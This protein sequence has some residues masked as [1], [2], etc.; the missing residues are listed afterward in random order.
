M[1]FGES[2]KNTLKKIAS[3]ISFTDKEFNEILKELQRELIKADVSVQQVLE[4][5]NK[6]KDRVK[7]EKLP[8]GLTKKEHVI[9]I[10]YDELTNLLG[11][12]SREVIIV[13]KPFKI[14]LV[15]LFGS[16]KTTTAGKLA[17]YYV[18]RGYSTLLVQT[19]TY[20]PAAL[21][22]LT[23]LGKKINVHVIGPK[24]NAPLSKE[25]LV[26]WL[27]EVEHTFTNY[28]IVI[29]DTAGRDSLSKELIEELSLLKK[30]LNPDE[31]FLVIGADIGQTAGKQARAFNEAVN[32]SGIIVTRMDG[33]ARAG[34]ALVA[35]SQ[36]EAPVIFIGV[37]ED[38]KDLEKYDPKRF[39]S[40]LLGM[41][42]LE[43]LLEKAKEAIDEKEAKKLGEKFLK[44][45]FTLLDMYEQLEAM[46][47]MG[48]LKKIVSL[49]PGISLSLPQNVLE[50]QEEK[51]KKWK[52]IMQSMTKEELEQPEIINYSRV[53]RISRGSGTKEE[54]VRSLISQ[55]KKMKKIVKGMKGIKSEKDLQKLMRKFKIG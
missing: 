38:I 46:H 44:G 40:R 47:K 5:T 18:K 32:I 7:K 37:G 36:T 15:G 53:R 55:Y 4:I 24:A 22:Q 33:T 30:E 29:I 41:G 43:T 12:A 50:V 48:P 13:K 8:T 23:Q 42:D 2:L 11:K 52:Y 10:L 16:G 26:K 19:D 6:I 39:V 20:R 21:E 14:M 35:A 1:I 31:V 34:G 17:N 45:D 25:E 27:K 3:A 28:D 54:E 9:N 51:M 49:I